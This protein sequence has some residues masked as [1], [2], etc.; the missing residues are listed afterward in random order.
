M[1]IKMNVSEAYEVRKAIE[2]EQRKISA[3]YYLH[4]LYPETAQ[5]IQA[6]LDDLARVKC[7]IEEGLDNETNN[8]PSFA[9]D[10]R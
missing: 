8:K 6:R 2:H 7:R 3:R 10:T 5:K 9:L 1:Q 4:E